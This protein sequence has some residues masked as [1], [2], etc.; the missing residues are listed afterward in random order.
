MSASFLPSLPFHLSY[1][2]LF[3]V[4]LV[5]GMLG[6]ELARALR[7]PR[8]IGYV[9]VGFVFGPLA[10]A[11][12]MGL[13]IDEAR[14]FVDLALGLVLFDLGRRMDLKWMRRDWSLA[15]SGLAESVLSFLA[16]YLTLL[17]FDFRPM[18]A[19]IAAAIAMTT[20]P[21]VLL[22]TVHDTHAEGQ[23]TER[24]INLVALNGLLASIIVTIMLGSAHYDARMDVE[25]AILHPLY[26][27]LG[28]LALGGA[29]AWAARV[30]ARAVEKDREVHFS[31]IA[32][33]VV[34][35]VG[36]A[37][38]LKLPVILALLSF[39]LFSRNDERGYELL[40][41]NLAPIGR[42]LYIVLFVITGAS[43]PL[44]ML[45]IGGMAAVALVLAR[46][47]GKMMGV[48]AAAPL[49]GLRMLQAAGL[50]LALLP[51]SSLTLLLQHDIAR[52]YPEYP[53]ELQAALV[54]AIII[55][56][57]AGPI[58]VQGGLRLAGETL[59]D[60]EPETRTHAA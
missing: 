16:V 36:L 58:A 13:L 49:G 8:I 18:H 52:M 11:M 46:T 21:A 14:I 3:G 19:G 24:S 59:P 4:L 51:M 10:T 47:V 54:G 25:T 17:A 6:G 26:L 57:I 27:F 41:V 20:S 9:V 34:G 55:M 2:L 45:A 40:N 39:G 44:S 38:L 43:M 29:M 15:L 35:A 33:L 7:V 32:G 30:V 53:V 48:M 23:V 60:P 56:E 42:L 37:T 28:S 12:G 5:A 31:L 50:G 22:L 1:P